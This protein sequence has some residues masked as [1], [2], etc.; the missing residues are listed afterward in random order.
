MDVITRQE[1]STLLNSENGLHVSLYLPTHRTSQEAPQDRTRLKNLLRKAEER[2]QEQGLRRTKVQEIIEP[3]WE[4]VRDG[5]VLEF[6]SDGA[7]LFFKENFRKAYRLPIRVPELVTTGITFH[8]NPLLPLFTNDG[9]FYIL[10]LSA[11]KVRLLQCTPTS[12]SPV[13]LAG[14]PQ[15]LEEALAYDDPEK[16]M[17]SHTAGRHSA[18]SMIFHGN[19]VGVDDE[20]DRRLRFFQILAKKLE[21]LLQN[22]D[23]PLILAAVEYLFPLYRQANRYP[24]LLEEGIP[25]NPEHVSDEELHK[26]ALPIVQQLFQKTQ[27]RAEERFRQLAGTGQTSTNIREILPSAS[28]GRVETLFVVPGKQLWGN[29]DRETGTVTINNEEKSPRGEDLIN[30]VVLETLRNHGRVFLVPAQESL[31]LT[32]AGAIFRY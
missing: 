32:E 24:H 14:I 9:R 22:E 20:K 16:Q 10:A 23:A 26:K 19:A 12:C 1:L 30:R 2:L 6:R 28:F 15:S 25:G 27:E 3:A 4:L 11:H 8:L 29:F 13:N 5:S 21:S 7:G 18:G 31:G 17:Q